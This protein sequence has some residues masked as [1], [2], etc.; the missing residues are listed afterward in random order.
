M[1]LRLLARQAIPSSMSSITVADNAP[2]FV[3]LNAASGHND[4]ADTCAVIEEVLNAAGREHAITL[5]HD[6]RQLETMAQDI[7]EKAQQHN[8][9]VVM[10]G[11]DGSINTVARLMLGTGRPFGVLP[12]GTF[13]LFSRTH[14][15][16]EALAEAVHVL[17]SSRAEAVHIAMANDRTFIVNASLGMYPQLFEDRE[18][19]K[20]K[21]GRSRFIAFV[22][23]IATLLQEHHQLNLTFQRDGQ[24][25]TIRTPTLFIGNNPLQLRQIGILQNDET[26][27]PEQL[28]AV[29]IRPVS[30][31]GIL[32]LMLCGTFGKLGEAEN[33]ISFKF[34][35]LSI[36]RTGSFRSRAVKIATD[37]E[38]SWTRL[39]LEFRISPEPL[40]LLKPATVGASVE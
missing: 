1:V 22:A 35:E 13:N 30:T 32:W 5:V 17:L 6:A 33:V 14:T 31:L 25:V 27:E 11:G 12:L 2:L 9:V 7:I 34:S 40:Y 19:W 38:V 4:T 26:L 20:K 10:A 8:G 16:P 39:P 37:G 36:K 15:I 28:M 3:L 23:G 21:Y 24:T 18:A 29:T